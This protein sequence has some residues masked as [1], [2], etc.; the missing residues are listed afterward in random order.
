[1][2]SN[3]VRRKL[4]AF[5]GLVALC[6]TFEVRS[7]LAALLIVAVPLFVASLIIAAYVSWVTGE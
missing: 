6:G 7:I 4:Y 2:E 1:M 5:A 3:A